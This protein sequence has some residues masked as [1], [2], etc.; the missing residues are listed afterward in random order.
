ML[1]AEWFEID[2]LKL[3]KREGILAATPGNL[4]GADV[5]KALRAL[6]DTLTNAAAVAVKDP[7]VIDQ[8]FTKL[9]SIEGAAG[10]LRGP[11]F[12]MIVGHCVREKEGNT[13]DIGK[14][15]EDPETGDKTDIDV[16]RVKE[17]QEVC[18]YEC[19]GHGPNVRV[20]YDEIEKWLTR[21]IPTIRAY[22]QH[23]ERFR[24]VKQIYEFW[25]TGVF[26]PNA[27]ALLREKQARTKKYIIGWRDK[28]AVREYVQGIR[29][30]YLTK[31][32]D[33]HYFNHPLARADESTGKP[34]SPRPPNESAAPPVET[35]DPT[36]PRS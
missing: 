15:V 33:E 29:A 8:L 18:S 20:G 32:L 19:K 31:V 5:A 27:I 35:H 30:K 36:G 14:N 26:D 21:T 1:V 2:A 10:N 22:M 16:L 24:N 13:I 3:A 28:T 34:R 11:L 25:T 17:K 6:L 12:E 9:S 23:Q 4:F 7:Q